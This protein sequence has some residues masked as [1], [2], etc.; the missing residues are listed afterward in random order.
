VEKHIRNTRENLSNVKETAQ[1]CRPL[2]KFTGFIVC[3]SKSQQ[4]Y[5]GI[6]WYSLTWNL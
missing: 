4:G 1:T 5:M 6:F 3:R 2:Y